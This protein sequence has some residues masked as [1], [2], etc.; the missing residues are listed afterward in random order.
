[1]ALYE[2]YPCSNPV[3]PLRER[4]AIREAGRLGQTFATHLGSITEEGRH[5]AGESASFLASKDPEGPYDRASEMFYL[6]NAAALQCIRNHVLEKCPF[7]CPKEVP[8]QN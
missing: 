3:V 2:E 1:M 5:R 7:D 6:G 4:V 8:G